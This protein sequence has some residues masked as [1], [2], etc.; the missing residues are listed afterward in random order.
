MSLIHCGEWP[1]ITPGQADRIRACLAALMLR[2]PVNVLREAAS[3]G[4][5]LARW[6]DLPIP[7]ILRLPEVNEGY[8][9]AHD[10]VGNVGKQAAKSG[11]N[12]GSGIPPLPDDHL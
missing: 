1:D 3:Y 11:M 8:E 5:L 10:L 9:R 2:L 12:V 7:P 4:E 6:S